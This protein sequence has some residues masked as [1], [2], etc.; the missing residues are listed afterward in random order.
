MDNHGGEQRFESSPSA[1]G[2]SRTADPLLNG[3]IGTVVRTKE[4]PLPQRPCDN[5]GQQTQQGLTVCKNCIRNYMRDINQLARL[6]PALRLLATK[7]ARIGHSEHSMN[8]GTAPLPISQHWQTQYERACQT[9]NGIAALIDIR[10][11]LLPADAWRASYRKAISNRNLLA[12]AQGVSD[13]ML[14]LRALLVEL[15][16]MTTERDPHIVVV[17]CPDCGQRIAVPAGMRS[18][19]CPACDVALDL[20]RLVEEHK[21]E[22]RAHMVEGSPAQLSRWLASCGVRRSRKQVEW[23]IRSGRLHDCSRVGDGVWKVRAGELLDV[24][25]RYDGR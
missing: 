7:Q 10:Y 3:R 19:V 15:D 16:V 5:C 23:I 14:D 12:S 18:G 4:A 13:R 25:V 20:A 2:R 6:I 21:A 9:M 8:Q 1:D 22:A 24:A 11:R 17:S